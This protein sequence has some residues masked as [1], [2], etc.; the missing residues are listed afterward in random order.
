MLTKFWEKRRT[1]KADRIGD[2]DPV[3]VPPLAGVYVDEQNALQY[4]AVYACVRILSDTVASLPWR[5]MRRRSDGGADIDDGSPLYW[6]LYQAPNPEM[7]A[8]D[9]KRTLESHR[10]LWGNGYAE[11]TRDGAGRPTAMFIISPDRVTAKRDGLGAIVYEI[12]NG[13]NESVIVPGVDMFH[14]RGMSHD[15][16]VGMSPIALA[17]QAI[18]LGIATEQFGA[19]WFGNGSHGSAVLESPTPLA[20]DRSEALAKQFEKRNRGPKNANRVLVLEGGLQYK[21]MSVPPED[22]QFLETRRFQIEELARIFGVPPH[23]L[24]DLTRAT[25][26]NI[27]HQQTE[28]VQGSIVPCVME[29]EAEAQR[30]LIG[31]P[32]TRK[33]FTKMSVQ[34]I[35]RG[36]Q[37]ARSDYYHRLW[38]M[39]VMSAN[40]IRRLEDMNPIPDG[41]GH[42]VQMNLTTLP[43]VAEQEEEPAPPARPA[44]EPAEQDAGDAE[45]TEAARCIRAPISHAIARLLRKEIKRIERDMRPS[46]IESL[47]ENTARFYETFR[48][49]MSDTIKPLIQ[50]AVLL[51]RRAVD[52]DPDAD[53]ADIATGVILREFL[54]SHI[55]SSEREINEARQSGG[56]RGL[57]DIESLWMAERCESEADHIIR[58]CVEMT[59]L[60]FDDEMAKE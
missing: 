42:L 34:A 10:Q 2:S 12:E 20:P 37:A 22:A 28:F 31:R 52:I 21:P 26:S 40:E 23:R 3:W 36:D 9:F 56:A 39:G 27:E 51:T 50:S 54:V 1:A 15:G 7:S 4:S 53:A 45:A 32:A 17:R 60:H 13:T 57:S 16:I 18:G 55:E 14:L 30:K 5:L 43:D 35:M 8:W 25:F 41:D 46:R 24:A 59:H 6:M 44:I 48:E 11:I 38:T 29:F 49:E 58:S 33:L 19:S 47:D